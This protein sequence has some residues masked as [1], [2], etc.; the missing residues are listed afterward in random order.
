MSKSQKR[1]TNSYHIGFDKNQKIKGLDVFIKNLEKHFY[2][3]ASTRIFSFDNS[4]VKLIVDLNC[5]LSVVETLFHFNKGTW[6]NFKCKNNSFSK[7]FELLQSYNDFQ[8]EIE[9]LSFFL[10]DTSIII[11]TVYDQSITKQLENILTEIGNHYV[12]F[13]QGLTK[14]PYEIYVPVFEENV[15]DDNSFIINE[16]FENNKSDFFRFWGL[17]YYEKEDAI[18]YDLNTLELIT[19]GKLQMLN[20]ITR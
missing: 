11:N 16:N 1:N 15:A 20:N 4:S 10:K 18:I 17:Y 7:S 12:Y 13:T 19:T 6:G 8:I 2:S 9:E 5:N 3:K 14:I